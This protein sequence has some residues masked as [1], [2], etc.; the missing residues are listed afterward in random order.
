MDPAEL[1]RW[2]HLGKVQVLHS[3]IDPLTSCCTSAAKTQVRRLFTRHVN[4]RRSH[5]AHESPNRRRTSPQG[6]KRCCRSSGHARERLPSGWTESSNVW[7]ERARWPVKCLAYC[8]G[9]GHRWLL[10]VERERDDFH[11]DQ[12]NNVET[13]KESRS[14]GS[15]SERRDVGRSILATRDSRC[16]IQGCGGSVCGNPRERSGTAVP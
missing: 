7:S 15:A 10:L 5:C 8:V 14:C 9:A 3:I 12:N 11:E 2:E 13:Q 6:D 1:D 4:V 16:I